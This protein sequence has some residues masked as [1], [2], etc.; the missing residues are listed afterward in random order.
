MLE[1]TLASD[2]ECSYSYDAYGLYTCMTMNFQIKNENALIESVKGQHLPGKTQIDVNGL[3][4]IF[5]KNKFLSSDIFEKFPNLKELS[6]WFYSVEKI[7]QG[8]FHG[9]Q[10]LKRIIINNNKISELTDNIFS[11]ASKLVSVSMNYNRINSISNKTF[12]G[13]TNLK[14]I[15]LDHNY[16][17]SLPRGIFDD[18]IHLSNI[19]LT[20]NILTRLDGD[21]FK[22][23]LKITNLWFSSNQLSVIGSNLI[24]PLRSL[25][26]A[27]FYNNLC[28]SETLPNSVN[29]N[30]LNDKIA[31]CTESN[32]PEQKLIVAE[33]EKKKADAKTDLVS[34]DNEDLR[35]KIAEKLQ[36]IGTLKQNIEVQ[37]QAINT[38]N[39]NDKGL[40]KSSMNRATIHVL[41]GGILLLIFFYNKNM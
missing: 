41:L 34:K 22:N 29:I 19:S 9:A 12:A 14:T 11:G 2:L 24:T 18:L 15:N 13:L 30:D 25:E 23:N 4:I 27:Y 38:L 20:G 37:Q 10:H 33:S 1:Y 17:E 32:K 8:N 5:S 21:L 6:V 16:L 35:K 28:I 36:E 39:Q 31:K 26:S 40:N 3:M 7:V